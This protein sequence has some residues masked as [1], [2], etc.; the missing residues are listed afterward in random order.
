[1]CVRIPKSLW[2]YFT[3]SSVALCLLFFGFLQ[4]E[5]YKIIN[6]KYKS[7]P[8]FLMFLKKFQTGGSP[9]LHLSEPGSAVAV[10]LFWMAFCLL[11]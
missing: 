1:M 8:H 7:L 3:T 4:C 6:H 10:L 2:D 5:S 11:R 9:P